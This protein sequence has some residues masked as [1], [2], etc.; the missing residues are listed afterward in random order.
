[1]RARVNTSGMAS[2]ATQHACEHHGPSHAQG[3]EV[4]W[5]FLAWPLLP[6][7]MPASIPLRVASESHADVSTIGMVS[8]ASQHACK[9]QNPS[10][11]QGQAMQME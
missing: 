9:H 11:A 6:L 5:T 3:Q 7:G 1:M 2:A 10:Q 4:I 8:A